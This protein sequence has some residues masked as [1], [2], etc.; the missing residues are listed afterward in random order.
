MVVSRRPRSA[1]LAHLFPVA[2]D[3]GRFRVTRLPFIRSSLP[4]IVIQFDAAID[5][6]H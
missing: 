1:E 6:S 3:E 5:W 4:D 2:G